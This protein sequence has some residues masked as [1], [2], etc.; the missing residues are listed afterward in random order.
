MG[1]GFG[2]LQLFL[3]S[4]VLFGNAFTIAFLCER[5]CTLGGW[6]SHKLVLFVMRVLKQFFIASEIV[7][8][9]K[10]CGRLFLPL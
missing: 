8:K 3:K 7:V 9:P 6:K 1:K 5:F 10:P 4:N 2:R